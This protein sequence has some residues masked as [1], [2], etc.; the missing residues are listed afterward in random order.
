MAFIWL[1]TCISVLSGN[2]KTGWPGGAHVYVV[3][4]IAAKMFIVQL[5]LEVEVVR[6][7]N[8]RYSLKLLWPN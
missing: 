1:C 6:I 3:L 8:F 7:S 4:K 2:G 5:E